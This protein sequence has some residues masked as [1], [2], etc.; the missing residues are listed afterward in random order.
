M[1]DKP[2][3]SF[4]VSLGDAK[5]GITGQ[6]Y[7]NLETATLELKTA[8]GHSSEIAISVET[9]RDLLKKALKHQINPMEGYREE[10]KE[11]AYEWAGME[12]GE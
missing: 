1:N 4:G 3:E 9:A 11:I 6:E 12:Y 7:E 8:I 10:T 5:L 2:K